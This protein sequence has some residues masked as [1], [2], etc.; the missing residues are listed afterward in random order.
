M[1][2][3]QHCTTA[4]EAG[5]QVCTKCGN[6]LLLLG[7]NQRW[8]EPDLPR[9]SMEDHFLERISH[10]EELTNQ[11][12]E[13]VARLGEAQD[14]FERNAFVTRAG[15]TAL[16]D[17]LKESKLLREDLLYQ[18]WET[19][20]AEQMEEARHRERFSHMKNRFV[21]LYRG[22]T[23]HRATFLKLIEEAELLIYSDRFS[24]STEILSKALNLDQANYELA[25]YLAEDEHQLGKSEEARGYLEIALAAK[26]DHAGALLLLGL[27]HFDEG[28]RE[29]AR[30][31]LSECLEVNPTHPRAMLSLGALYVAEGEYIAA[32][33]L[34]LQSAHQE[35]QAQ[36]AYLLGI[37]AKK[38][39]KLK[40]A[41][42]YLSEATE[43]DPE[44]EE[45]VFTLGMVYLERGWTRKA[46]A[47][48]ARAMELN[49][50]RLGVSEDPV[51][52]NPPELEGDTE[53]AG[54]D[55]QRLEFAEGLVGKGKL[56]QALP[57]YRQLVKQ[58]PE[59]YPLRLSYAIVTFSLKRYEETLKA[60]QK[61]M[62]MELPDAARCMA[63]TLEMESFR[64]LA[65]Y[66]EAVA[67]LT[68]MAEVFPNGYGRTIANYGLALTKA[69]LGQDLKAAE[70]L[71]KETLQMS[72]PEFRHNAL[73]ALGWVY[74]KQGRLEEALELLENALSMQE[75]IKHLYHYGMI[76]LALNLQ[77]EAFKVFERTVKLRPA[78]NP[79]EDFVF[80]E[81]PFE[82][83]A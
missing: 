78:S 40:E 24:E 59:S 25:F 41:I 55:L 77:E 53:I 22:E 4:N 5:N 74:F 34:L 68:E 16:V 9:L 62:S 70:E 54:D 28:E 3:C 13:Q 67:S 10:L 21:A 65:R 63:Y 44:H 83:D 37:I 46:R 72:P 33:P 14:M 20:L 6:K 48:F 64:A 17:T 57:H 23:Q 42:D 39:N 71:A 79:I 26:P 19:T 49:P 81:F 69:D 51:M 1:I 80:P 15:V 50:N 31:Y 35:P 45:A 82:L 8:E 52:E 76:L 7:G 60:I 58:F 12:Q 30:R 36:T 11:L 2:Y 18:R 27:H 66:D 61:T 32:Q 43:L 73:D 75:T 38:Q 47:C 29:A 56:K